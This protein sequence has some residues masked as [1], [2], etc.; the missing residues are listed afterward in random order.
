MAKQSLREAVITEIP[1]DETVLKEGIFYTLIVISGKR[2]RTSFKYVLTDCG[3]WT[4]SKGFLWIKPRV[5][6]LAYADIDCYKH[7]KYFNSDTFVFFLKNGKKPANKIIFDD[8]PGATEILSR[9]IRVS[10]DK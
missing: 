10:V 3:M 5:T 9:Y 8:M 4:R 6:F 2:R 7:S 1:Q